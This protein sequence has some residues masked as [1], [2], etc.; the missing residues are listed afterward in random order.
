V[1]VSTQSDV[2]ERPRSTWLKILTSAYT[3]LLSLNI[4]NSDSQH[5]LDYIVVTWYWIHNILCV[6]QLFLKIWMKHYLRY[7]DKHSVLTDAVFFK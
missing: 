1:A 5:L 2:H 6:L 4:V 3:S 7:L